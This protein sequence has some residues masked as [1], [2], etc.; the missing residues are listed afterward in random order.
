MGHG[1]NLGVNTALGSEHWP[2]HSGSTTSVRALN[3]QSAE[4]E[5]K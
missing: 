3:S 4:N 5:K 1:P 2:A